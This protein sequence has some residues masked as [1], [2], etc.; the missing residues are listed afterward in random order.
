M[1]VRIRSNI[2]HPLG[3]GLGPIAIVLPLLLLS[4]LHKDGQALGD[5]CVIDVDILLSRG[6][7]ERCGHQPILQISERVREMR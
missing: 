5:K 3:L 4:V 1:R 7:T 6:V 2:A